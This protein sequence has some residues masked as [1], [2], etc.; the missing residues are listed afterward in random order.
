MI[1]CLLFKLVISGEEFPVAYL[2][3]LERLLFRS[4]LTLEVIED[5]AVR[6]YRAA[7]IW[8]TFVGAFIAALLSLL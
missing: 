4:C 3:F 2:L 7:L 5:F 8:L 6:Q 1:I